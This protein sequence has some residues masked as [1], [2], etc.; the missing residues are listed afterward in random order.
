[1]H[2][3]RAGQTTSLKDGAQPRCRGNDTPTAVCLTPPDHAATGFD[4][5]T[6]CGAANSCATAGC[7]VR[8]DRV[9]TGAAEAHAT[10]TSETAATS[11][12]TRTG[13]RYAATFNTL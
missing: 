5:T 9:C 1:M 7:T 8:A 11:A 6:G 2:R 3:P 13:P 12:I 4:K 10:A